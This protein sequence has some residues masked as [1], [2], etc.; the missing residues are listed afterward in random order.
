MFQNRDAGGFS[1]KL[2]EAWDVT[3]PQVLGVFPAVARQVLRGDVEESDVLAVRRVH[4]PSL[5]E[6]K[7]DFDD[8]VR[9]QHDLKTFDSNKVPART[10]AVARSVVEFT[11]AYRDTPAFDLSQ[12][13]AGGVLTSTT[14]QLRWAEGKEKL[15]GHVTIDTAAT[16]A[17]VGF[18]E[19][20][21]FVLGDVTIRPQCPF[22]AV[23]VTAQGQHEDLRSAKAL[24]VVA[25]ARARNTGMN[26]SEDGTRLLE[27]GQGPILMEPVRATVTLRRPGTSKVTLLDHDGLPT[28]RKVVVE[29]GTFRIDGTAHRTPYYIVE[30]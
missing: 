20:Q 22:A 18:A 3:V 21:T 27:K 25:V 17:V 28:E 19:G 26:I 8:Q 23:Y 29:D 7:L 6:G 15:D 5:D 30:Y 14:G 9:Q 4:V 24:L 16:K 12:Y 10:L 2:G 1:G 11:D 13:E